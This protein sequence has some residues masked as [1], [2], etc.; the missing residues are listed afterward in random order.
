MLARLSPEPGQP[1]QLHAT[2]A[3]ISDCPL[4]QR[5]RWFKRALD[6][7]LSIV[8]MV[9]SFPLLA[10]ALLAVKLDSRGPAFFSQLRVGEN[11]RPFRMFKIRTMFHGNSDD[12]HRAFKL[13]DDRRVT[14]VGRVLRRLSIDELPQ[15][16]N[17]LHG[18]MS[19]VGP[20]PPLPTEVELYDAVAWQRLRVKPGLTGLWQVSGRCRLSFEDMVLL[21]VEYWQNWSMAMD[22]RILLRTVRVVFAGDGAG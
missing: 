7:I 17:V 18:D 13:M 10:V 9:L 22:L 5:A 20:R 12:E 8:G 1:A 4:S 3:S 16:W 19:L 11:G 15:L 21:D 6:I 14:R 2:A